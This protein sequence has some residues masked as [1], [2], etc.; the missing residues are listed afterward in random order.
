MLLV[1]LAAIGG[2]AKTF[3]STCASRLI[4]FELQ[5]VQINRRDLIEASEDFIQS[6][7]QFLRDGVVLICRAK[8]PH[9][10]QA[11]KNGDL[12]VQLDRVV[13]VSRGLRFFT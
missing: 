1:I 9:I 10:D 12:I 4:L 13:Q 3:R 8:I 7:L 11:C 5:L 2:T 6:R